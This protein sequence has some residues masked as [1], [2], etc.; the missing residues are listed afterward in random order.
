MRQALV[1]LFTALA[2]FQTAMAQKGKISG[3]LLGEGDQPIENATVS[4][5]KASDSIALKFAVSSKTGEFIFDQ[6]VNGNYRIRVTAMGYSDRNSNVIEISDTEQ[7]VEVG[8]MKLAVN[9]DNT[10][11][12]RDSNCKTSVI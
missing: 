4:L 8:S 6:I 10:T 1:L 3:K 7:V 12:S 2:L 11:A 5:T 9:A